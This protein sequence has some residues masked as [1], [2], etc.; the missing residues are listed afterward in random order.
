MRAKKPLLEHPDLDRKIYDKATAEA[1]MDAELHGW[2]WIKPKK[3]NESDDSGNNR[4]N[5]SED[6]D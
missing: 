1:M 6:R 4:K 5:K 3:V 2:K